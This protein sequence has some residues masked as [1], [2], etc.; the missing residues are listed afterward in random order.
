MM[1]NSPEERRLHEL[2]HRAV[3][4]LAP[5]PPDG[6]QFPTK[7]RMARRTG[8]IVASVG[9]VAAVLALSLA[10]RHGSSTHHGTGPAA[11][12][13]SPS[14]T[15]ET[16]LDQYAIEAPCDQFRDPT[17]SNFGVDQSAIKAFGAVAAVNCAIANRNYP[18]DGQWEVLIRQVLPPGQ[19]PGL[20]AALTQPNQTHH[21]AEACAAVAYLPL[22]VLL[23]NADGRYLHPRFPRN[24]CGQPLRGASYSDIDKLAW[25]T[26]SVTKIVQTESQEALA[27]GCSM[28][29]KNLFTIEVD[30][31]HPDPGSPVLNHAPNATLTACI[32]KTG[33]DPERG[34]FVRA[35]VLDASQSQE[36]RTALDG[37]GPAA[38][39]TC[40]VQTS[41]AVVNAVNGGYV[42]VE[43]GGCW[44]V[45]RDDNNPPTIGLANS[46][47]V[48]AILSLP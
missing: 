17:N 45:L 13:G 37:A 8:A 48:K 24:S 29:W 34:D 7:S 11:P 32:Y 5:L 6:L 44:R 27:S 42:S 47:S 20:I 22:P 18:G 2:F 30:G 35:V 31:A 3:P 38:N 36:L 40:A 14:P 25:R 19:L 23:V 1:T 16:A 41:F 33:T 4:D 26:V 43:L 28:L 9:V 10:L 21:S 46:T 15:S 39:T 12:T